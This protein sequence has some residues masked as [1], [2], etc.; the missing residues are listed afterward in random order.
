MKLGEMVQDGWT[1]EQLAEAGWEPAHYAH[2]DYVAAG[3]RLR[4]LSAWIFMPSWL[5]ALDC[6]KWRFRWAPGRKEGLARIAERVRERGDEAL[7]AAHRLG[8]GQAVADLL[9]AEGTL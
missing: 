3:F 5:D 7:V 2:K 9:K 1:F 4:S 8:G 6:A